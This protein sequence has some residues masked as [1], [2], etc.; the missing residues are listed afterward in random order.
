MADRRGEAQGDRPLPTGPDPCFQSTR[1]FGAQLGASARR[2]TAPRT[3]RSPSAQEIDDDRLRL[4]FVAC[5]PVLSVP[6][7]VALTLRLVGGLTVPEIARAYVVPEPTIAQRIVRAKKTIAKAGVPFEV[8]VGRGSRRT[9]GCRPRSHLP[10]LQRGLRGDDGSGL[11]AARALLRGA[12][13]RA[14]AHDAGAR[15]VR[16]PRPGRAHGVPVVA[17][18]GAAS[19]PRAS[20]CS[21]SSRIAV[22][23][24]GST[25]GEAKSLCTAPTRAR[26]E[27]SEGPYALQAAIAACHARAFHSDETDWDEVVDLYTRAGPGRRRHRSSS[28]TA[29]VAV[30]MATGPADALALVDMLVATGTLERYHLLAGVRGDLLDRRGPTRRGRR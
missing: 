3:W 24:T 16:D 22:R 12:P 30:S 27:R 15:G 11:D 13:P 1:R 4:I 5:H 25:S 19:A 2:T 14:R 26:R 17:A 23:G 20:R 6:A 7:R 10:H 8:P 18:A 9:A 28:S 21:C 29:P